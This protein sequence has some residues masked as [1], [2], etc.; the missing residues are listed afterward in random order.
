VVTRKV[1]EV[2]RSKYWEVRDA[3]WSPDSKWIAYS[4]QQPNGLSQ[5]FLYSLE[6]GKGQRI[7]EGRYSSSAPAFSA[8]GNNFF[9]G[10]ARDFNPI[11]SDAGWNHASRDMPR[12]HL[13]RL[14]KTTPSPLRPRDED[15]EDKDKKPPAKPDTKKPPPEVKVDLDGI[16]ERILQMPVK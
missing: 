10:S 5:V 14:A 16:E 12:I 13:V 2:T 4:E 6:Q 3:A 7:T 15:E 9:R 11:T 8:D 1:T